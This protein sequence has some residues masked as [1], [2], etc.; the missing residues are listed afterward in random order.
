MTTKQKKVIG[1][2]VDPVIYGISS[3]KYL[4]IEIPV[5]Y[6]E[7]DMFRYCGNHGMHSFKH[8]HYNT[9]SK[10][11]YIKLSIPTN[12]LQRLYDFLKKHLAFDEKRFENVRCMR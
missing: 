12:K 7:L 6:A 1:N 8:E 2:L 11:R 10:G 9:R 4:T 3:K 5:S